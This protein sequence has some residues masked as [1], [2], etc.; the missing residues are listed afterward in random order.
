MMVRMQC[1][2]SSAVVRASVKLASFLSGLERR[3]REASKAAYSDDTNA[4]TTTTTTT[5]SSSSSSGGAIAGGAKDG[6]GSDQQPPALASLPGSYKVWQ[7]V[8]SHAVDE[9]LIESTLPRL[10][11]DELI[12]AYLIARDYQITPLLA[13]YGA[14][15]LK[16]LSVDSLV[17]TMEAA[18]GLGRVFFRAAALPPPPRRPPASASAHA[19]ASAS[20]GVGEAGVGGRAR[21]VHLELLLGCL[22][23][24]ERHA[25]SVF[26]K[27]SPQRCTEVAALVTQALGFVLVPAPTPVH[28]HDGLI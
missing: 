26:S 27:R 1:P 15:L 13:R 23:Y 16:R 6:A 7:E 19:S 8:L 25:T 12:E 17:P 9:I 22:S 18:L 24:I 3:Q 14:V 28:A 5:T 11:S 2:S 20:E 4:T 21:E 10:S